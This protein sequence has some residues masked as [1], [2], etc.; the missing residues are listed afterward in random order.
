MNDIDFILIF[1]GGVRMDYF[2]ACKVMYYSKGNKNKVIQELNS[3]LKLKVN[4]ISDEFLCLFNEI[5]FNEPNYYWNQQIF[6]ET[7]QELENLFKLNHQQINFDEAILE[8]FIIG[9]HTYSQLS[10]I[11]KDLSELNDSPIIK[12]RLYRIP[13][14]IS[15]VEGGLTNL[16]RGILLIIDQTTSKDFS[17][18][19]KLKPICEALSS[20]GF[21]KLGQYVDIDIR[22]AI[23]H[24]N[25]V[26]RDNGRDINFTYSKNRKV[27]SKMLKTYEFDKLLDNAYDT[28]SAVL[29][30]FALFIN[31]HAD[32]ININRNEENFLVLGLFSME[33]S[34]PSIR[35]TNINGVETSDQQKQ[36]NI[37]VY[38]ENLDRTFILQ[39]AVEIGILTY[40]RYSHY[41]KYFISFS[42]ERLQTSWVRFT[43]EEINSVLTH[44]FEIVEAIQSALNRKDVIIWDPAT[45]E[46]DMQEYKYYRYPNHSTDKFKINNV[47]DASLEDR[48][49]LKAHLFVGNINNKQELLEIFEEAINWLKFVR[50]IQNPTMAIKN[51]LMAADALYINVYRNDSRSNR[52]LMPKNENFVCFIDYNANGETT[53][54]N[55]GLPEIIWQNL[56]HEKVSNMDLAWREGKHT[57]VMKVKRP[58]R[59]DPCPCG[60]GKKYKKCCI[61]KK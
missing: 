59:N 56:Y 33:L 7:Y 37:D 54:K 53:L 8:H 55:G 34:L 31:N 19:N 15:T 48:K 44:K 47:Q 35:V 40:K 52:E 29:L 46:I 38:I 45:H 43:N 51:G 60:S 39:T 9:Y 50:N 32:K 61:D 1:E 57:V 36:L 25:V 3:R 26:L 23:N 17:K 41:D 6:E 12:N 11:V 20:N 10:D 14:Y 16:F 58:G 49:R 18:Q 30:A 5:L 22:N 2:E 21:E 4:H 28:A 24:G 27:E 42:N 13:T